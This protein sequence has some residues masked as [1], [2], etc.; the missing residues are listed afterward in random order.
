[1]HSLSAQDKNSFVCRTRRKAL[2]ILKENI[3]YIVQLKGI[4]DDL[5][6]VCSYIV[7]EKKDSQ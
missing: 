5:V 7:T 4:K 3:N 6:K 1:M 2:K